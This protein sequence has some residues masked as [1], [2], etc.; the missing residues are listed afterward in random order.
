MA[1][2]CCKNILQRKQLNVGDT[3]GDPINNGSTTGGTQGFT[4]NADTGAVVVFKN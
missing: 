2:N 1:F 3:I 4:Y